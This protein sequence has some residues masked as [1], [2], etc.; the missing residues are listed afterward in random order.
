MPRKLEGLL[1]GKE[2]WVCL[3][4]AEWRTDK[5]FCVVDRPLP[6]GFEILDA[7]TLTFCR[8][9]WSCRDVDYWLTEEAAIQAAFEYSKPPLSLTLQALEVAEGW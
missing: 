8:G 7:E 1:D 4:S 3:R 9:G 6:D 5:G 2:A